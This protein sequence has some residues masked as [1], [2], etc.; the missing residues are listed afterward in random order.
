VAEAAFAVELAVPARVF[1]PFAAARRVEPPRVADSP[2]VAHYARQELA[3]SAPPDEAVLPAEPRLLADS[4]AVVD[5]ARSELAALG[6]QRAWN[7]PLDEASPLVDSESAQQQDVP[8][9]QPAF[10]AAHSALA[11]RLDVH[12]AA[13]LHAP[14]GSAPQHGSRSP[15]AGPVLPVPAPHGARASYTR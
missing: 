12:S 14:A 6:A 7:G 15:A 13:I 10:P 2:A 1:A 3:S 4:P 11:A 9:E 5:Y 8:R